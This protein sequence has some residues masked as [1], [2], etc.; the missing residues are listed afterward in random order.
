MHKRQCTED[1]VWNSAYNTMQRIQ[2]I[3]YDA[4]NKIYRI[5]CLE[6]NEL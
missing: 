3:E 1:N 6:Y 2:Y 4:Y 5:Q